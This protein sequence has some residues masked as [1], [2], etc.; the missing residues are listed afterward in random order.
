MAQRKYPWEVWFGKSH[1]VI[2]RGVDYHLSQSMMW[3]TIR[4]NARLRRVRLRITDCDDS[5]VIEVLGA[6]PRPNKAPVT[7]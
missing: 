1:T 4:N 2:V 3:Q 7:G 5:F 6:R